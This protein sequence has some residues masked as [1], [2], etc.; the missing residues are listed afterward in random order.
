[1]TRLKDLLGKHKFVAWKSEDGQSVIHV[2]G[3]ELNGDFEVPNH[4]VLYGGDADRVD[5]IN[6]PLG[7]AKVETPKSEMKEAEKPKEKKTRKKRK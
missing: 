6:R 7:E 3:M 2:K 5:T 1:M 4:G